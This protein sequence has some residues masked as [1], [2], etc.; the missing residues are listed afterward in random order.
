[1]ADNVGLYGGYAAD[2]S[3]ARANTTVIHGAPQAILAEGDTG[4]VLQLLTLEGERDAAGSAY[5]LRH[6]RA[7]A[8][9]QG[10]RRL[11]LAEVTA[12]ALAGAPGTH[13]QSGGEAAP[14]LDGPA[15]RRGR[16]RVQCG[17]RRDASR[18]GERRCRRQRRFR[19]RRTTGPTE[20]RAASSPTPGR[21]PARPASIP[22]I[23]TAVRAVWATP[24][25]RVRRRRCPSPL[26]ANAAW[27]RVDGVKGSAGAAGGGGGGGA[28]GRG[29]TDPNAGEPIHVCGGGGGGGGGGG[30]GGEPGGAGGGGGGSFGA[31]LFESSLA[32]TGS[33]LAG[34]RAAAEATAGLGGPGGTGGRERAR[35]SARGCHPDDAGLLRP[36]R[37]Q[38]RRPEARAAWAVSSGG[39]LGGPSAG[40]FQAGGGSGFA[41]PVRARRCPPRAAALGGLRP[42]GAARRNRAERDAAAD[43]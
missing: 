41:A 23:A 36:E 34:R 22:A 33:T 1:M 10:H 26:P 15:G 16:R 12:R 24:A 39:G 25:R 31:Y 6:C 19:L 35:R 14:D 40:V 30:H 2:G 4:V 5:G 7:P 13:G 20:P 37:R 8:A 32:A 43:A 11:M 42:G 21:P 9:T 29:I 3:R 27:S 18:H 38:R 17:R 28:G